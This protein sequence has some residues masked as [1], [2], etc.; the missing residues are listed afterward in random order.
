MTSTRDDHSLSRLE[1][2]LLARL[3]VPRPSSE[4]D[5]F[6]DI[7][8]LALL[9][10]SPAHAKLK[11]QATLAALRD[12]GLASGQPRRRGS[13]LWTLTADGGRALR[14]AFGVGRTPEWHTVRDAHL[15]A[16][17]LGL[18]PGS[19]QATEATR[20]GRSI[21]AA[22][23]RA[24]FGLQTA[25]TPSEVCDAMIAE[26]L[27]LPPGPLTLARIRA[28]VFA[29]RAGVEPKGEPEELALRV[30]VADVRASNARKDSMTRALG[31]RWIHEGGA[32]AG[33][34]TSPVESPPPVEEPRG[35]RLQP[36][37]QPPGEALLAMIHEVI[38]RVGAEGRFGA[39]KV[40]VSAIWHSIE[41]DRR[42]ADLSLDRFKRW[43]VAANR[44]GWLVLANADLIGA[45]DSE[46]IA[47]SEIRDHG[48]T[49]HFVLDRRAE[50]LESGKESHVR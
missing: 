23:L 31:R 20:R 45:M 24:K 21:A 22:V 13:P 14:E 15:P 47:E 3:S 40:F 44:D 38:S 7:L 42:W 29:R 17:A 16:L 10:E 43:L 33:A 48:A 5:L 12:Q 28:H 8:K 30:A 32:P 19:K 34:R 41:R 46:L 27:G 35:A 37:L 25:A 26:A 9:G 50:V 11:I 2:I 49:F 6:G 36:V 39:A 4:P 18:A 1:L